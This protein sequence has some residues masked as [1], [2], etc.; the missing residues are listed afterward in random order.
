MVAA[1][2]KH[3]SRTAA[4]CWQHGS[5]LAAPPLPLQNILLMPPWCLLLSLPQQLSGVVCARVLA[6][7][8][9]QAEGVWKALC[10]LLDHEAKCCKW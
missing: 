7:D 4:A 9:C 5:M 1:S 6:G 3:S 10:K 2:E 8:A